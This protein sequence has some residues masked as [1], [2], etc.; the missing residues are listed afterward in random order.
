[1]RA[2][3]FYHKDGVKLLE[4]SIVKLSALGFKPRKV[5]LKTWHGFIEHNDALSILS[6][7]KG[8]SDV[9]FKGYS[10][11][12]YPDGHG[13]ESYNSAYAHFE[14]VHDDERSAEIEVYEGNRNWFRRTLEVYLK[15]W[16][17]IGYQS[18]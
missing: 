16:P 11:E 4:N 17:L 13:I 6:I 5:Q 9:E 8:E 14:F 10:S 7:I 3:V 18:K 1:M 12:P 2:N 15:N